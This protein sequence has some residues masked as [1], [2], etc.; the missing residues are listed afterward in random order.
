MMANGLNGFS[1]TATAEPEVSTS[2][3][4]TLTLLF[5]LM[6]IAGISAGL[7]GF[8]AGHHN[9]YN[10]TREMPWGVLISSYAFFAITSTG[11]CVL[12]EISHIF[13]GNKMAP[14][15]NRMVWLSLITIIGG[16]LLI[17]LELESPW[18][19]AIY[20]ITSP[21]PTS[22][23]WWMGTLYGM[24]VALMLVE[25][26][27]ILIKQYK[28]AIVLGVIGA[29]AEVAANTNLGAVFSTLSSHPFWYGSQL[30]IFF[31]GNA[32]M[33]GAAAAIMFTHYAYVM[34]SR[35]MDQ[36]TFEGVQTAGKILSL[37]LVLITV[38]SAW[39]IISY[40]VG[41]TEGGRMAAEALLRGSLATN[42]WVFEITVGLALPLLLLV[43]TRLK[44]VA[45][46]S[47][48]SLMT[49]IGLFARTYNMVVAG[50]VVPQFVGTTNY[51]SVFTY[52]PSIAEMM[53]VMAGIG[54]VG[55]AFILGERFFGRA[56]ALHGD[57]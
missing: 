18:R 46:M 30:P 39:R 20:N 57:H 42:F 54:V 45:A 31:L 35:K 40:F 32:F 15:A 50:Q 7:Y 8:Y 9:V 44:S 16:F 23:I 3:T 21:N 19:M 28:V 10:N 43:A 22:N 5:V 25:F 13:G 24:A 49:L 56:Y 11:L 36:D 37:M 34:R 12:A 51:P 17:G 33:A 1:I 41:G 6:A 2:S 47:A 14:L 29:L 53:L 55:A 48:A 38:A 27:L 52:S 26:Y 4:K